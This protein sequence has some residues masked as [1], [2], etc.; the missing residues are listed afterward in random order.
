MTSMPEMELKE[1]PSIKNASNGP[2]VTYKHSGKRA[3]CLFGF[4]FIYLYGANF[5]EFVENK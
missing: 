3:M 4:T 1:L 2:C 5:T